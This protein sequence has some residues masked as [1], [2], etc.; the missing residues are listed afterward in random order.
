MAWVYRPKSVSCP[1]A[2]RTLGHGPGL[3]PSTTSTVPVLVSRLMW[4]FLSLLLV[5]EMDKMHKRPPPSV[6]RLKPNS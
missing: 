4:T 6:C 3:V 5:D 2:G 1:S